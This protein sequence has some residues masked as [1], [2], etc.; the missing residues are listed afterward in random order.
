[1]TNTD[2]KVIYEIQQILQDQHYNDDEVFLNQAV[3]LFKSSDSLSKVLARNFPKVNEIAKHN[4]SA[5]LSFLKTQKVLAAYLTSHNFQISHKEEDKK[6]FEV[7]RKYKEE[8]EKYVE[9][10]CK[11]WEKKEGVNEEFSRKL[12][13]MREVLASYIH[14]EYFKKLPLWPDVGKEN[15]ENL[16]LDISESYNH[17]DF[18]HIIWSCSGWVEIKDKRPEVL[19]YEAELKGDPT[20]RILSLDLEGLKRLERYL[21]ND[22]KLEATKLL[23]DSEEKKFEWKSLDLN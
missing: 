1:M 10:L 2:R 20:I 14:T 23:L 18:F 4:V 22:G 9:K 19:T 5:T 15:K 16:K 6:G 3:N 8:I 11:E 7:W 12:L 13:K 21:S 17:N